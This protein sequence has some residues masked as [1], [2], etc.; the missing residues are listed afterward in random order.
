MGSNYGTLIDFLGKTADLG[1]ARDKLMNLLFAARDSNAR[2]LCWLVYAL[3]REPVV[4]EKVHQEVRSVLGEG[5]NVPPTDS[6]LM[7]MRYLD[8]VIYEALR[9]F[10]AVPINGRLCRETTTLPSGG[11]DSGEQP[12]LVPKGTL[13]CIS[14]S[15]CHQSTEYYGINAKMFQPE[16]WE[17]VN[18]ETRTN[19]F[20]F[21]PFIGGPRKCLG[22]S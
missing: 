2:L 13:I 5:T 16:R 6:D 3:A 8:N 19:D 4:F 17:K 11:G 7:E 9:L 10:P 18:V 21:H 22:G 20:T 12:I 1:K 14:T 15:A